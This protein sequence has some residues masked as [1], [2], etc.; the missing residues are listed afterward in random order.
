MVDATVA[1]R[2]HSC[3]FHI[4]IC[5]GLWSVPIVKVYCLAG[6]AVLYWPLL[7]EWTWREVTEARRVHRLS[8]IL[9]RSVP[10]PFSLCTSLSDPDMY[11]IPQSTVLL[12]TFIGLLQAGAQLCA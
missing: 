8:M 6:P 4:G 5:V 12:S 1:P 2:Y 3:F 9:S 7:L 10:I 11:F